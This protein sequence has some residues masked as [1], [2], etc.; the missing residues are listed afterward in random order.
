MH[1]KRIYRLYRADSLN[2]YLLN[3]DFFVS[4]LLKKGSVMFSLSSVSIFTLIF[5]LVCICV[6]VMKHSLHNP[7]SHCS[8]WVLIKAC[9]K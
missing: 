7:T 3:L 1:L 4:T 9:V 8:V 5:V 2:L 6:Y